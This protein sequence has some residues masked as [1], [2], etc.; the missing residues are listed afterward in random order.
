M[1]QQEQQKFSLPASYPWSYL[2]REVGGTCVY[3]DE[4]RMLFLEPVSFLW[5]SGEITT[6][7][8]QELEHNLII[9]QQLRFTE[10]ANET[11]EWLI[12]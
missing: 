10:E 5:Q 11:Q 8:F 6:T 7:E 3:T 1:G 12:Y 4:G 9:Q 2:D